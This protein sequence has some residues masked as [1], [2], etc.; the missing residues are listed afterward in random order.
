MFLPH[1]TGNEIY[2]L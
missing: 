1:I 2:L